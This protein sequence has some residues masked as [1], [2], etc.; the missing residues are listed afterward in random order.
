[1]AIHCL[2]AADFENWTQS[3][4]RELPTSGHKSVIEGPRI[5]LIV[6][7]ALSYTYT[8]A[9]HQSLRKRVM[10]AFALWP[11]IVWQPAQFRKIGP[12]LRQE[13]RQQ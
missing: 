5:L 13:N 9:N 12:N 7:I 8:M 10:H 3:E 4:A 1:M 2:A 6:F 11:Y